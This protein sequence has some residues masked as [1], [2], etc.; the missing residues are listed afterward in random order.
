[1]FLF[2]GIV[3]VELMLGVGLNDEEMRKE[4][5]KMYGI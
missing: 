1:M 3:F 2:T 5:T 4:R